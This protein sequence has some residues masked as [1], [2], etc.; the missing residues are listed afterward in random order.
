[1]RGVEAPIEAATG[2]VQGNRLSNTILP[3]SL[4]NITINNVPRVV[5]IGDIGQ[6]QRI[7]TPTSLW[8]NTFWVLPVDWGVLSPINNAA[9]PLELQF[10]NFNG[11]FGNVYGVLFGD[12]IEQAAGVTMQGGNSAYAAR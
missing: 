9:R 5:E 11:V 3:I 8:D 10:N 6:V 12:P 1:M 4:S 2:L 7:F